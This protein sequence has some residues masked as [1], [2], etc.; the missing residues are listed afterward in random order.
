VRASACRS[1][2]STE[3][4]P[5]TAV[6]SSS[7]R[8]ADLN[9]LLFSNTTLG[10]LTLQNRLVMSPMT[11]S[12]AIGNLPNELMAQYYGQRSSVGLI[13][14]EGTS[15]SP[16]GLGY[17]R[18]PGVF[19]AAQVQGWT[20][21]APAIHAGHAAERNTPGHDGRGHPD[22][23]R[24]SATRHPPLPVRGVQRYAGLSRDEGRLH[25]WRSS[26]TCAAWSTCMS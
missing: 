4:R 5:G 10:S 12:R 1:T 8:P 15:P 22:H 20:R 17:A 7:S 18:I 3:A 14:A 26:S 19:S 21:I 2:S 6:A 13:V 16:N 9:M 23:D 24:R 25:L 11:R